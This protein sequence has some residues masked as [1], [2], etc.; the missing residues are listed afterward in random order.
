M[1]TFSLCVLAMLVICHTGKAY[2]VER[3]VTSHIISDVWYDDIFLIADK[4]DGMSTN[5]FTVQIGSSV[6]G[7][8]LYHFPNWYNIKFAPKLHYEDINKDKLKDVIVALITDSGTSI[9]TK[10]IHVLNQVE[11]PN[12]RYEEVPVESI[13]DAVGRF[14]KMEQKGNVVTLSIGEKKYV[15]D[16]A[17]FGYATPVDSP[18][19]GSIEDYTPENGVLYGS[20]NVFVTITEARIGNLKVKYRWEGKMYKA[21]SVTFVQ[22]RPRH[23]LNK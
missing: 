5:N 10:E 18:G 14:V 19:A 12:R 9:S 8:L 1:K 11:D 22:E 15:V 20:T 2:A 16:Y 23:R 6:G 3:V 4:V 21:E 17:T 13:H 7:A